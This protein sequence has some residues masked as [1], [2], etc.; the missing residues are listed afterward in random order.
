MGTLF[1]SDVHLS[2]ARPVQ[3]RAFLDMLRR[4]A[5]GLGALYLLGDIFDAWLGDDDE[6]PLHG[7]VADG[8]HAL[9]DAGTPVHLMHG[10]HDF[11]LGADYAARCGATLLPDP[12]RADLYGKTV[13]LSHGDIFCTDD[14]EYQAFRRWSREPANQRAFLAM[15]IAERARQAAKLQAQSRA[16][17][18]RKASEI[19]D[20][21][22]AAVVAALR[23]NGVDTLVHGHTHRPATHDVLVG[24]T[25]GKRHVLG[26]WYDLENARVLLWPAHGEP[27][28]LT[29]RVLVTGS[30]R[31]DAHPSA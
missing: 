26:D 6:Q 31:Q 19:M 27:A 5:P 8:L 10:N 23:E 29:P 21:N 4:L 15:P 18:R 28:L 14:A 12:V 17:T 22:D 11:L 30:D 9:A 7:E 1:V 13:L 25:M 20:V 3:A 16:N 2:A 24:G